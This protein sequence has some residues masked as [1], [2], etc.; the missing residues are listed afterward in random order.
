MARTQ[1]AIS[2][3]RTRLILAVVLGAVV[4]AVVGT[5]SNNPVAMSRLTGAATSAVSPA[6]PDDAAPPA[7]VRGQPI[8]RPRDRALRPEEKRALE[9]TTVPPL[10]PVGP[11]EQRTAG[12]EEALLKAPPSSG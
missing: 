5:V 12:P 7:A 10:P 9:W 2:P 11:V 8:V 4:I 3:D 6:G 1:R